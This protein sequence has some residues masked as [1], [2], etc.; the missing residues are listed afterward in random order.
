[1]RKVPG[2]REGKA[3][4]HGGCAAACPSRWSAGPSGPR[5]AIC[6]ALLYARPC[7]S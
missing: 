2:E 5:G 3:R 7:A 6:L 4:N 1:M